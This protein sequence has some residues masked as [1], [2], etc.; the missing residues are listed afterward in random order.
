M[1]GLRTRGESTRDETTRRVCGKTDARKVEDR[2]CGRVQVR[3]SRPRCVQT[4][5][6]RVMRGLQASPPPTG[7]PLLAPSNAPPPCP[8][9]SRL[10][11]PCPCPAPAPA[12][13]AF[14]LT[15]A[16]GPYDLSALRARMSMMGPRRRVNAF[17]PSVATRRRPSPGLARTVAARGA[18]LISASSARGGEC[19]RASDLTKTNEERVRGNGPPK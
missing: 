5:R 2:R 4:T 15:A 14:A 18:E 3:G 17:S 10:S 7:I 19:Q 9:L 1:F 11:C 8:K 16:P 6:R 12:A 13:P